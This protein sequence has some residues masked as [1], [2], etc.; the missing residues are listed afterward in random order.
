MNDL[1]YQKNKLIAILKWDLEDLQVLE[2]D[3]IED[4]YNELMKTS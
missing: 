1:I 4:E 3:K 2:R